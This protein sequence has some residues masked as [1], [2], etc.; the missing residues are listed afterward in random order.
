MNGRIINIDGVSFLFVLT[1]HATQRIIARRINYHYI[2]D[3]LK[4]SSMVIKGNNKD[5]NV[6]IMI[7]DKR[8]C[9]NLVIAVNNGKIKII[10]A[11]KKADNYFIKRNTIK[12]V[13]PAT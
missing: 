9:Y 1:K 13:I 8:Y 6:E 3:T 10:T 4:T 2:L 11:M 5:G 12:H 7:I